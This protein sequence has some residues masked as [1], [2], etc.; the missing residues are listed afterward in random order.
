MNDTKQAWRDLGRYIRAQREIAEISI[1]GLARA[2]NV[3]DS[4]LSQVERGIYKPSAE[5]LTS[6]S[7]ALNLPPEELFRRT[8]WLPTGAGLL[9]VP[10]AIESDARLSDAQKRALLQ[11]YR[12]MTGDD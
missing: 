4:Y 11:L 3:S 5:V 6:I 1:R 2:A 7:R 12:T 8:G 9:G 10:R